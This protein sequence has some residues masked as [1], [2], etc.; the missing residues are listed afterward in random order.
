MECNSRGTAIHVS[1]FVVMFRLQLG[2]ARASQYHLRTTFFCIS[3]FSADAQGL[4]KRPR[5]V[6]YLCYIMYT[7]SRFLRPLRTR[8]HSQQLPASHLQPGM[9]AI[10]RTNLDNNRA[11]DFGTNNERRCKNQRRCECNKQQE[12]STTGNGYTRTL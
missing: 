11:N 7:D 3:G 1:L 12:N 5:Y 8:V 9:Y 2:L 4:E 6:K 10:S